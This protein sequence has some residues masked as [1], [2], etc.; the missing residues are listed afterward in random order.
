MDGWDHSVPALNQH[1]PRAPVK[2]KVLVVMDNKNKQ[3]VQAWVE[4][5]IPGRTELSGLEAPGYT[6]NLQQSFTLEELRSLSNDSELLPDMEET[7][8]W[9]QNISL[10]ISKLS[11]SQF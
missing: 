2:P 1:D 11:I 8:S 7:T 6:L 9:R 4:Y 3:D 10:W 5:N